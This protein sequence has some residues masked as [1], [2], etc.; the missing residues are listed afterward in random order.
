MKV[1][2]VPLILT[3]AIF[4]QNINNSTMV[5]ACPGQVLDMS[6][7]FSG[8]T[9]VLYPIRFGKASHSAISLIIFKDIGYGADYPWITG[10]GKKNK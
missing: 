7:K 10:F 4:W 6:E 8:S 5:L 2:F 1:I 3:S 9:A